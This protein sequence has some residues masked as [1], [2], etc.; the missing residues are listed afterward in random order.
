[1][2]CGGGVC[3]FISKLHSVAVVNVN[4][5]YPELE[6]SCNDFYHEDLTCRLLAMSN[7]APIVQVIYVECLSAYSDA[8]LNFI[9]EGDLNCPN[10]NWKSLRAIK[11]NGAQENML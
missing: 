8:Q 1:V 6:I 9:I 10:I 5:L 4:E 11:A 2:R 3:K 7:G